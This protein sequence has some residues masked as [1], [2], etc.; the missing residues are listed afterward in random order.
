MFEQINSQMFAFGKQAA[1][2]ALKAQSLAIENFERVVDLHLKAMEERAHAAAG[3]FSEAAE[4]RDLDAVKAI[5]PKGVALLKDSA[6]K[7][8]G[9]SQELMNLQLKAVEAYAELVKGQFEAANEAAGKVS[10]S[11]AKAAKAPKAASAH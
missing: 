9:T 2:A 7:L 8:Y 1:D 4:V 11:A 10:A 5:W 6:E 3:F